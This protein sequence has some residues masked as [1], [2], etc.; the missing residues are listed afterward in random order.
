MII[1]IGIFL[2]WPTVEIDSTISS[3]GYCTSYSIC[4]T[5]AKSLFF[6]TIFQSPNRNKEIEKEIKEK[7]S[8]R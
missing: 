3:S 2:T 7:M 1:S 5:H 6:P 8:E 4:N